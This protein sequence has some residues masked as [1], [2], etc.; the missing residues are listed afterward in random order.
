MKKLEISAKIALGI[1]FFFLVAL[2]IS[3]WCFYN[4]AN[5][6]VKEIGKLHIQRD[7]VLALLDTSKV[8]QQYITLQQKSQELQTERFTVEL[9]KQKQSLFAYF[10]GFLGVGT[11]AG[12]YVLLFLVPKEIE[13]RAKLEVDEKIGDAIRGRSET[14]RRILSNYD[15]EAHLWQNKRIYCIGENDSLLQKILSNAGFNF[16]N[17][18]NAENP[19]KYGY[20]ILFINNANGTEDLSK[21]V[22]EVNSLPDDII[23]FYYNTNQKHFPSKDLKKGKEDKVNFVNAASQ[24]YGNLLN[25]LKYQDKLQQQKS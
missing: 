8:S 12:F 13:K 16:N 24:I 5:H 20:D 2:I 1:A 7:S 21:I 14:V 11:L 10:V 15:I 3:Q 9:E 22:N 25:T 4:K 19:P 6:F 23:A 17:Y 18:Y